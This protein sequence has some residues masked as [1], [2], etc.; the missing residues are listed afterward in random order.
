MGVDVTA[1]AL[2]RLLLVATVRRS[3]QGSDGLRHWTCQ[4]CCSCQRNRALSCPHEAPLIIFSHELPPRP[5]CGDL[6]VACVKKGKPELRKKI[7]PAV[8]VRQ[9]KAWRR[10]DGVFIYFEGKCQIVA[11]VGSMSCRRVAS[12]AYGS[13]GVQAKDRWQP[14]AALD[15]A[16]ANFLLPLSNSQITPV[17]LSTPRER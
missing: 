10:K 15:G 17:S 9:R 8:V 4:F 16:A 12:R 11:L 2:R 13:T 6:L 1:Q 3:Q 7:T 14:F 5:G